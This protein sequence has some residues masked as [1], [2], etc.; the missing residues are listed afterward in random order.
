MRRRFCAI[1]PR[2]FA[3]EAELTKHPT[4][5]KLAGFV[6]A[7]CPP[8]PSVK[9]PCAAAAFDERLPPARLFPLGASKH[10]MRKFLAALIC[11]AACAA[12]A[13]AQQPEAQPPT[14]RVVSEDGTNRLPAEIY[15]GS[16]KVK[17]VRLRPGTNTAITIDDT[18]FFVQ[19][20]Y[21][22]FLSRFPDQAGN[23]FWQ[24]QISQCGGNPQCI[25][26]ARVN[27]SAAFFLSIE[28]QNTGYYVYRMYR[29][30]YGDINPPEVP[31]PVRRE[32]FMADTRR[33][34][35]GVVVGVGNWEAQLNANKAA[36]AREFVS[37]GRF[38]SN[39]PAG[40]S[41]ADFVSKLQASS[42]V[43]LTA[44]ERAQ[45]EADLAPAPGDAERRATALRRVAEGGALTRAEFNKAFVLM[46][47]FGY[48]K[49]NPNDLP[50]KD[51]S[52]FQF[53]LNQLERHNGN[54]VTAELVKAFIQ[55]L[56]YRARF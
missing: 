45:I 4:V 12:P 42:G 13:L 53:W 17:P 48:L 34:G 23:A 33:I 5:S 24:E 11:A 19:Q 49:R 38:R 8:Q 3:P 21:V 25:Q 47:Y 10:F 22:D 54:Y 50:D 56:E 36:W 15:Y 52:G 20:H 28:F 29:A 55:S 1:F 6:K 26:V 51:Y 41:P 35:E 31:V 14:L 16:T 30:A 18:D 7:T 27:V 44:E 43:T 2:I 40:M 32:E 46:Q 39:Y 9:A 37:T